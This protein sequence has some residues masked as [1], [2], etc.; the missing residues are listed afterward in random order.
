[1]DGSEHLMKLGG[2]VGALICGMMSEMTS[3]GGEHR[4]EEEFMAT[5]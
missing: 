4:R 1:V 2:V 3:Q 5:G